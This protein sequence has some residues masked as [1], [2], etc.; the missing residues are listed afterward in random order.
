[1]MKELEVL[2]NPSPHL[3]RA[4]PRSPCQQQQIA[5]E[6]ASGGEEAAGEWVSQW[7]STE[8]VDSQGYQGCERSRDKQKHFI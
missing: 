7:D 3:Q 4:A 6:N 5:K 8:Q 2:L 1:M